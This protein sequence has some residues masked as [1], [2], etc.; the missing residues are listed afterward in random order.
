MPILMVMIFLLSSSPGCLGLLQA[1]EGI[2]HLRGQPD[3]KSETIVL[4]LEKVF[5]NPTEWEVYENSTTFYVDETVSELIMW[6]HTRFT[7]S[8]TVGCFENFT[9]YVRAELQT[10]SGQTVWEID[11]CV[12]QDPITNEILPD[13]SGFETGNWNLIISARGAGTATA[14]VQDFVRIDITLKRTC[15][16]YPLETD[17]I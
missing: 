5:T 7:A 8:E 9:R 14:A 12:S 2:E 3:P 10:P 16:Q 13:T 1:R 6:R 15:I 17:C 4:K 11:E